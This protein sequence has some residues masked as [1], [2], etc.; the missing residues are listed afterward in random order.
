WTMQ[1]RSEHFYTHERRRNSARDSG[2]LYRTEVAIK[3]VEGF[4]SISLRGISSVSLATGNRYCTLARPKS[5]SFNHSLVTRTLPALDR[6]TIAF[7]CS[8]EG[9]A[10]LGGISR[11]WPL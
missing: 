6:W 9:V 7:V 4:L 1:N 5:S 10:D 11:I 2:L 8:L 3:P